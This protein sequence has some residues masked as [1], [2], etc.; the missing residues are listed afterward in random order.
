MQSTTDFATWAQ[1]FK[2]AQIHQQFVNIYANKFC[3]NRIRFDMLSDI[4][5]TLLNEMGITAI[6]DCLSI[7]KH[8]KVIIAKL[9]EEK[10]ESLLKE[11]PKK[12][13]EVAKR[14]IENCL[15]DQEVKIE[16]PSS[17]LSQDLIS[18]L[19]FT[20]NPIVKFN[21]ES[22]GKVVVS[23]TTDDLDFDKSKKLT[24]KRKLTEN[25]S[26]SS[27]KDKPLEY[28]GFLKNTPDIPQSERPISLN[29]ALKIKKTG[30]NIIKLNKNNS[31]ENKGHKL[32]KGIQQG[33]ESIRKESTE[34]NKKVIS[35][36]NIK[37]SKET[38]IVS[39][40]K[41]NS[42]FDR[43]KPSSG[44]VAGAAAV[45]LLKEAVTLQQNQKKSSTIETNEEPK[46]IRLNQPVVKRLNNNVKS[47][48]ERLSFNK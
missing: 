6:G 10:K 21:E 44:T 12:R 42:V 1:F 2:N 39:I 34:T 31:E 38:E 22:L 28:R 40:E 4:D 16:K 43:I 33:L 32:D 15:G 8:A 45:R 11:N 36:K 41:K 14:I 24:I 20:K 18:R 46:I 48:H 7:L 19:N 9:E 47:V 17:T 3:E 27:N 5:K 25:E 13:G 35:L 30:T 29:E 26:E 37:E 23:S